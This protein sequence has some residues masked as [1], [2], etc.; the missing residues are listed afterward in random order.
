MAF[1]ADLRHSVRLLGRSPIFTLTSVLSLALGIGAAAT[2]FSLTDAL[3]FEPTVGV[4][5]ASE[6]VD[7]G[8]ANQGSGFDNMSHPMAAYLRQHSKT[9]EIASVDFGG[10]PMS[11][12]TDGASERVIGTMVS[13]NYF[14]VLG[15]RAVLGRFFRADEDEIPGERPVVVLSHALWTERFKSDPKILDRPLR[16]NNRD[17]AVVGVAEPGF[18]GS[19]MVGTDLWVP[20]AMVAVVRGRADADE[21]SDPRVVWHIALGRLQRG[22]GIEQARA[23]LN[24]LVEA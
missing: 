15:T 21:L 9:T 1:T 16:L 18:Q 2:I 12:V 3:L 8:R 23:E 13:A 10:G 14:D 20:M 5:D 19:S 17:F 6:V 24:T 11:L 7:I 4:R 22:A